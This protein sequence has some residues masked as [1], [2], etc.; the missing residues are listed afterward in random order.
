MKNPLFIISFLMMCIFVNAQ[1]QSQI[2]TIYVNNQKNV[3]LFFPKPI[4]QGITGSSNFVFTYNR[5]KAQYFGLLQASPGKESNLLAITN[6]GHVY[7]YILKYKNRL[8]KLNYFIGKKESIGNEKSLTRIDVEQ[9]QVSLALEDNRLDYFKKYAKFL[10]KRPS[11][12]LKSKRKKGM[13]LRIR[14]LVYNRSEVYVHM[15]IENRSGIDF[16]IDYMNILRTNRN[17]KR[18][19]SFQRLSQEVIYKHKMPLKIKNEESHRLIY[20]L[21]KFVLGDNEKL[22]IELKELNGYRSVILKTEF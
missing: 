5:E 2:D 3:A 14:K 12:V 16:E 1:H 4:R 15:E 17:K 6:D 11:V 20:V 9:R 13:I 18:K 10:L 8:S 21:P 19:A 22:M 7:A